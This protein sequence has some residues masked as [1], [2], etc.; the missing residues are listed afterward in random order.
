MSRVLLAC[1]GTGGHVA[2]GIALA[3]R[4]TDEGHECLLIVSSKAVD[5][6]MTANYPRLRFVPGR[7]RGFGPGLL[8]K[9]RFFP[10]LLG[11]VWSARALLRGEE[12]FFDGVTHEARLGGS[13]GLGFD[14]EPGAPF[15]GVADILHAMTSPA[16]KVDRRDARRK[17]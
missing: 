11:A 16:A 17:G 12:V 8:N 7:G 3:Q 5:A 10:A 15:G 6:R 4:L 2:P 13:L 14:T 1:G 9:L